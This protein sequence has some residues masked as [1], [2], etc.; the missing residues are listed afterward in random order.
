MYNRNKE[1]QLEKYGAESAKLKAEEAEAG[2][3]MRL[4]EEGKMYEAEL[5]KVKGLDLKNEQTLAEI[6]ALTARVANET[7]LADNK[8]TDDAYYR[9]IHD[10]SDS[11]DLTVKS[12]TDVL[13]IILGI[14]GI[15]SKRP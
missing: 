9:T 8:L 2:T 5:S 6:A 15:K 1:M 3:K 11:L 13:R 4:Y 12:A 7:K 10:V 14:I